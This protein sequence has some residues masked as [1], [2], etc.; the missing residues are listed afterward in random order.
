MPTFRTEPVTLTR[1]F[2][3]TVT[4]TPGPSVPKLQLR[5]DAPRVQPP[6]DGCWVIERNVTQEGDGSA[7]VTLCAWFGPLFRTRAS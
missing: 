2:Q 1:A 6:H 5:S 3:R 7:R 4:C